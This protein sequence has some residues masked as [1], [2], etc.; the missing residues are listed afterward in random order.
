MNFF[1]M[2][3]V[4]GLIVFIFEI[5]TLISNNKK[6]ILGYNTLSNAFSALQYLFLNA[7]TG[8]LARLFTFVRN[9][10]FNYYRN[11]NKKIPI[12]WLI[13]IIIALIITNIAT[14]DGIISIIPVLTISLYTVALY[15]N[16][17]NRFRLINMFVFSLLAI[18]NYHYKAYVGFV[19]QIIFIIVC[20]ISYTYNKDKN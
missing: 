20:A 1:I 2:A 5:L 15:Q 10:I 8:A 14:Y 18:Y 7:Y 17:T 11:K 19:S 6:R 16:N 9:F 13:L 4:A 12:Y 3:Q